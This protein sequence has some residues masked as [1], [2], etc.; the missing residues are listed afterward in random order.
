MK[1]SSPDCARL[2]KDVDEMRRGTRLGIIKSPVGPQG[3]RT[4]VQEEICVKE[5]R[6][7]RKIMMV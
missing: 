5:R 4:D 3:E 6:W 7:R 1:Q 2:S